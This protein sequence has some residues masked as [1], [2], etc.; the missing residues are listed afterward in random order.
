MGL[1]RLWVLPDGASAADG[2]YLRFP[3]RDLLRLVALEAHRHWAIVLGEDLGTV[4]EGFNQRLTDAG[5][6][7][8][9]LLWFE[10][11][12]DGAFKPPSTW[13][14]DAVAMTSTHDVATV[15]G[16][17][18]AT[19]I[20]RR[21]ELGLVPDEAAQRADRETARVA[22]WDAFLDS[23][24]AAGEPPPEGK[25]APVVDAAARHVGGAA[26]TLV[27][28]PMEDAIGQT[29][30]P[31]LPGTLD[32]HP[33]WR[34]RLPDAASRILDVPATAARLKSLDTARKK[35]R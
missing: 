21:A 26:C 3:E 12:K 25:P 24:A 28:L 8:L 2:A 9:R 14:P 11:T 35:T 13:T 5:V 20:D 15:A 23:G 17:W 18:T 19:D 31:N 33:N 1:T 29:E 22:L 10:K 32:E 27:L 16:W 34:R 6:M 30:Q 4:P 7:G